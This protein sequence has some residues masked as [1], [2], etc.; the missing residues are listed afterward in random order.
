M[1]KSDEGLINRLPLSW[2][3][4]RALKKGVLLDKVC[5]SGKAHRPFSIKKEINNVFRIY[6][7]G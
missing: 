7:Q 4:D 3:V 6:G 1:G 5:R 2:G